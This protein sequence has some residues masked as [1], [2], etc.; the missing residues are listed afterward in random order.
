MLLSEAE[1]IFFLVQ[2]LNL[3]KSLRTVRT[4]AHMETKRRRDDELGASD[5][6]VSSRSMTSSDHQEASYLP[7][8]MWVHVMQF[9]YPPPTKNGD[10]PSR[11]RLSSAFRE[12]VSSVALVCRLWRL[13][14]PFFFFSYYFLNAD[15][16]QGDGYVVGEDN[17]SANA[18]WLLRRHNIRGPGQS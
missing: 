10:G 5:H 17:N 14:F 13:P 6:D 11:R 1:S 8:E 2:F 18:R 4:R 16:S 15:R 7:V 3:A 12:L 9:V